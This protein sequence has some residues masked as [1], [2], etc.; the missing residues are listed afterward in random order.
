MQLNEAFR[1]MQKG[2]EIMLDSSG[3]ES[4]FIEKKQ[5]DF[6]EEF[7]LY[8]LKSNWDHIKIQVKLMCF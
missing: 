6:I 4:D 2:W 7:W 5:Q 1:I 8:F 3:F